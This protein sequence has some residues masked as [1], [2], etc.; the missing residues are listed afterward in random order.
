MNEGGLVVALMWLDGSLYPA[1]DARP[2]LGVLEWIQYQLDR[3]G[4]V[5]EVL[6]HA[7]ETRVRGGTP[8]HYLIADASGDS[9]TVE[10]L[11]GKLVVHAGAALP[12]AALTNDSYD[13]SLQYLRQF[14]G[15]GGGRAMPGGAASLDRFARAA[16]LMARPS[17]G[18]SAVD[19][20][21]DILASVAQPGSTRWSVAYDATHREVTWRTDVTPSRKSLRF[22]AI[23]FACGATQAVDVRSGGTFAILSAA[24]NLARMVDAYSSTALLGE[25]SR[26]WIE[27]SAAHAESFACFAPPRSRAIR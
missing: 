14:A 6:A 25:V 23:D 4:S 5:A 12:V 8:L 11:G 22:Q 16:M 2:A 9:A 17:G 1:D 3:Y 21:L 24:E 13:S 7:D 19:R 18:Q 20:T 27:R 15:F 26:S 10:Y